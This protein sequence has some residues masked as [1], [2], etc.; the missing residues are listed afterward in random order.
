[1]RAVSADKSA[2][3]IEIQYCEEFV[4]NYQGKLSNNAVMWST[5]LINNKCKTFKEGIICRLF[6]FMVISMTD[7]LKKHEEGSTQTY[8][9]RKTMNEKVTANIK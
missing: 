8:Y 1:M 7:D 2:E 3:K 9:S 4:F 5:P 6:L